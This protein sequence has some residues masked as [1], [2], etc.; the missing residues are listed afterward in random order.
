MSTYF[1]MLND[2]LLAIIISNLEL[3]EAK[4]FDNVITIS[5]DEIWKQVFMLKYG[6]TFVVLNKNLGRIENSDFIK[7]MTKNKYLNMKLYRGLEDAQQII[8]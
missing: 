2:D 1:E 8:Y 3:C 4:I 7:R 6:D 5:K